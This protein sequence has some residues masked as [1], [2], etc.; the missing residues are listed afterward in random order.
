MYAK[1]RAAPEA[2]KKSK[3][4]LYVLVGVISVFL[5]GGIGGYLFYESKSQTAQEI[6]DPNKECERILMAVKKDQTSIS[7]CVK[8]DGSLRLLWEKLPVGAN[9]IDIYF[10]DDN[11]D[12]KLWT[13]VFV[14]SESGYLDLSKTDQGGAGYEFEI[15][16]GSGKILMKSEGSSPAP[17]A[18]PPPNTGSPQNP[19][20]SNQP[21]ENPPA[22]TPP[23]Q[24]Q[25][26][27]P[28]DSGTPPA[29]PTP[30][31]SPSTDTSTQTYYTPTGEVSGTSTV[32]TENFW[33][34]HVHNKIEIGW[35]NIPSSTNQIIIYRSKTETGG[36]QKLLEQ[37]NP[38]TTYDFLR[39]DDHTLP[40][41]YYYK[42]ETKMNSTI[43]ET[44]GPEF[45]PS[46]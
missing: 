42:M 19:P 4:Y 41:A 24:P 39:I 23:N 5:V 17:S 34:L 21:N 2:P 10:K 13:T 38:K 46:L 44:Y 25:P 14:T 16:D 40:E 35:Q 20:P 43:L 7:I 3:T 37:Q 26:N 18:S 45:L 30:T 36:Y 29:N 15:Y 1:R 31:S 32:P 28:P 27:L 11:G 8:S 9:K 6:E 22:P 33:V 12:R